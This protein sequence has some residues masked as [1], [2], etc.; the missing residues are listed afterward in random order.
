MLSK[1]EKKSKT[2]EFVK[3]HKTATEISIIATAKRCNVLKNNLSKDDV[4][5]QYISSIDNTSKDNYLKF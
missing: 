1:T 2:T 4:K 5:I 3:I